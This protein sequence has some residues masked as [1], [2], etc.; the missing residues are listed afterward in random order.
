M[1][2]LTYS[3]SRSAAVWGNHHTVQSHEPRAHPVGNV[4]AQLLDALRHLPLLLHVRAQPLQLL[5]RLRE[6]LL[7][8]HAKS[9]Q[10]VPC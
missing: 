6:L 1:M 9:N 7:H 5:H 10:I 8:L 2:L 4:L 3:V